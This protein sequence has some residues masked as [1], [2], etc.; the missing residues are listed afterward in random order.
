MSLIGLGKPKRPKI[1][2][3][4]EPIEE[5]EVVEED[6]AVAARKRKKK[7]VRGGR[8]QTILSGITALLKK[9]LGE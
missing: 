6:A 2:A 8:G 3:Q 7:L 9:R 4:P 1:P 5:V